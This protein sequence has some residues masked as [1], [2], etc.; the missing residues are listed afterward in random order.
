METLTTSELY[1]KKK[2][3]ENFESYEKLIKNDVEKLKNVQTI[4]MNGVSDGRCIIGKSHIEV[5]ETRDWGSSI[6]DLSRH[7]SPNELEIELDTTLSLGLLKNY[8]NKLIRSIMRTASMF[9]I[10]EDRYKPIFD[11]YIKTGYKYGGWY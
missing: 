11:S 6:G 5:H 2:E 8:E 1:Q 3:L 7:V 9:N 10:K 4:I